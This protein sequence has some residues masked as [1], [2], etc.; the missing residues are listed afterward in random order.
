MSRIDEKSWATD[1]DVERLRAYLREE[2][3]K[4]WRLRKEMFEFGVSLCI[5]GAH[6][7]ALVWFG[8]LPAGVP[9]AWAL[10][11]LMLLGGGYMWWKSS[12][13]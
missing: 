3:D 7:V 8:G 11:I 9:I 2:R 4:V 13:G 6:G 12:R 1:E 10:S 5:F